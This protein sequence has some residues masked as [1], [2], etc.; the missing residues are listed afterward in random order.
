MNYLNAKS[1]G[2]D[3]SLEFINTANNRYDESY[4]ELLINTS[5]LIE[6]AK[7]LN[8]GNELDNINTQINIEDIRLLRDSMFNIMYSIINKRCVNKKD[9]D[10]Y[11]NW[12]IE[13]H[14]S[15]E[16]YQ[17]DE[18]EIKVNHLDDG[19]ICSILNPI[20]RS[21]YKL[22][23]SSK[24]LNRVKQCGSAKCDWLFIDK[25]RNR[26]KQWCSMELCGNREKARKYY[27]GKTNKRL[28]EL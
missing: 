19:G 22:L 1:I 14:N 21:F 4:Q 24:T 26:S 28:K 27:Q 25:T 6:W 20:V 8:L 9:I 16:I 3:L 2:G 11:N 23:I 18:E 13:A 17:S 15:I 12:L 5:D 7:N 10:V